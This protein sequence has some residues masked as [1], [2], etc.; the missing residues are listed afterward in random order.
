MNPAVGFGYS[1]LWVFDR[2]VRRPGLLWDDVHLAQGFARR[3]S[4]VI[5]RT[6]EDYGRA[7]VTFVVGPFVP[8]QRYDRVVAVPFLVISGELCVEGPEAPGAGNVFRV[9]VGRYRLVIGQRRVARFEQAV[10]V[11]CEHRTALPDRSELLVVDS[12]LSP[13]ETLAETAE[14]A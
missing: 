14:E 3:G 6:M 11:F 7:T 4:V 8:S 13:P 10:D 1:Q 5:V 12:E 9:P 2:A